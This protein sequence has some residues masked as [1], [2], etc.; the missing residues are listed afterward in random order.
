MVSTSGR[1]EFSSHLLNFF[2]LIRNSA[3]PYSQT[4]VGNT[5]ALVPLKVVTPQTWQDVVNAYEHQNV[6]NYLPSSYTAEQIRG[7]EAQRVLLAKS[8]NHEDNAVLELPFGGSANFPL[9]LIKPTSRGTIL[10]NP[11]QKYAEP[12]LNYYSFAN[13]VDVSNTMSSV[14]FSRRF[15]TESETM[16]R[17]FNATELVPGPAASSDAELET[18][19]RNSTTASTAHISGTCALTPRKLGGVVGVDLLV[20]GVTGLS[21]ADA[22]I[23]PLIPA[24]HT[25]ST[26]YA[27]AEKVS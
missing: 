19:V 10:L 27:I 20:F 24:A 16:I 3:G 23:I 21:V 7:Y 18:Y 22:S 5:A 1:S 25:C 14:K 4:V 11:A 13:P 8:F 26:V 17:T 9:V 12:I 15:N 6:S 2:M